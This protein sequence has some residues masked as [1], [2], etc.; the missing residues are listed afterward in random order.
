MPENG[1]PSTNNVIPFQALANKEGQ[2]VT[3]LNPNDACQMFKSEVSCDGDLIQAG[4]TAQALLETGAF[5]EEEVI[6]MMVAALRTSG[7]L[8]EQ[9]IL[10]P[11]PEERGLGEYSELPDNGDEL[12]IVASTPI[13][14]VDNQQFLLPPT[15][16]VTLQEEATALQKQPSLKARI[17]KILKIRRRERFLLEDQAA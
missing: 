6:D 1:K 11:Q 17:S 2:E 16:S 9:R 5:N 4:V 8:M 15:K 10:T 14:S 13:T 3:A 12:L 7:A